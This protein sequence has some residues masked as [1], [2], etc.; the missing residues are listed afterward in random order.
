MAIHT[1]NELNN[2][3]AEYIAT[4]IAD[5][6]EGPVPEICASSKSIGAVYLVKKIDNEITW[7]ENIYYYI[8]P[9]GDY[10]FDANAYMNWDLQNRSHWKYFA[11]DN[12]NEFSDKNNENFY[13]HP[14]KSGL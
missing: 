9:N 14:L 2:K 10:A 1:R 8:D 4:R 11:T 7:H 6:Y 12:E 5:G 13:L 3:V